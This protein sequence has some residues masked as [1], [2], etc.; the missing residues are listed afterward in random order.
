MGEDKD[1]EEKVKDIECSFLAYMH[2]KHMPVT[3]FLVNRVKLQGVID[4]FDIKSILLERDGHRQLIYKHAIST[5]MPAENIPR[6]ADTDI[7][8]DVG[9]SS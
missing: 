5:I 9:A 7:N 2:K 6:M 4:H 3:V 1:K 8:T